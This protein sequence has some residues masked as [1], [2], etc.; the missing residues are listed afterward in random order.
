[1]IDLPRSE[2]F[3]DYTGSNVREEFN[4]S[5]GNSGLLAFVVTEDYCD[6]SVL[7]FAK[8]RSKAKS[9]AHGTD[10][11][12]DSDW[13]D[14][15]C[16][17]EKF[18]DSYAYKFGEGAVHC[19]TP[20]EARLLRDIGWFEVEGCHDECRVCELYQWKDVP[21]SKLMYDLGDGDPICAGCKES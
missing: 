18:A 3:D 14:L 12:C 5:S 10:W 9:Y 8:T 4:A 11:L 6:A 16:K 21:E 19:Q 1:M 7:V 13:I 17:R 2:G 15:R 20:D